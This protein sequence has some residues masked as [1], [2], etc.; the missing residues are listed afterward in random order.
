MKPRRM[1]AAQ[2]IQLL[3]PAAISPCGQLPQAMLGTAAMVCSVPVASSAQ[4]SWPLSLTAPPAPPHW[5]QALRSPWLRE[6]TD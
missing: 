6:S 2:Y 1:S 4:L 3:S 5:H